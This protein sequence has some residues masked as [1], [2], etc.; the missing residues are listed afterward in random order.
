[1]FPLGT[2][3]L[4]GLFLPLHVFEPR[5]RAL[6]QDCLAGTPEFGVAL[7]ERGQEVG[8]GDSR[9]GV[10][11]V[12]RIL[13]AGA[14]PDGRY[15]LATV[16]VRRIRVTEWLPEAPYPMAEVEDW[17]DPPIAEADSERRDAVASELRRVLALAAEVGEAVPSAADVELAADVEASSYQLA[18]LTPVGPL[19]RLALLA[20]PSVGERLDRIAG[21]LA[22][23]EAVLA[24]RLDGG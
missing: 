18:A 3:L 7:I 2:V 12:A 17:P 9:F 1:M 21:F 6:V 14:L 20:A 10:G 11:C 19:D 13:E 15:A 8:G 22:D 4:P 16:G 23:V 5:Y 24:S